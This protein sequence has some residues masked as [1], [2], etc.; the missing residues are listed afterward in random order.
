MARHLEGEDDGVGYGVKGTSPEG[1][2]VNGVSDRGHGVHGSSDR[3]TGVVGKSERNICVRGECNDADGRGVVGVS[4]LGIGVLGTSFQSVIGVSGES[5]SGYGV[6]GHS[7]GSD[8]IKG[9]S[10][11][12]AGLAGISTNKMGVYALSNLPGTSALGVWAQAPSG[13]GIYAQGGDWAGRFEGSVYIS[14]KLQVI[15]DFIHGADCAEDFDIVEENVDAGTVMVLNEMGLLQPSY[16]EYDKKVAGIISGAGGCSPAIIL[17]RRQHQGED[18]N[19]K[20][21][22][23]LPIALMGKVYCKVDARHSSI[24]IGDLLTTSSTKGYAMKAEDPIKAFGTVIGKAF[25]SIKEGLGLIPVLV[26]LQ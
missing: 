10:R 5:R 16:K 8:A 11:D 21:K 23:R 7:L 19:D 2:G 22:N 12:G 13:T 24:E 17:C 18:Q 3:N 25:G 4:D 20:K 6:Y 1:F 14:E 26:T 9:E 15:G